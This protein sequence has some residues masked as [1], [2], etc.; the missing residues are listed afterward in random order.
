MLDFSNITEGLMVTVLGMGTVFCV[1][2]II[3]IVITISSKIIMAIENKGKE[4]VPV[5]KTEPVPVPKAEPV[6]APKQ[7]DLEL[8]AVITAA[9]AMQ[10]NKSVDDLVVRSIRRIDG[11]NKD[12][13][14]NVF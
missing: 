10:E 13:Y 9:I 2:L 1:L 7:D 8:I 12:I 4:E 14:E 3:M 11:W 5:A 6:I